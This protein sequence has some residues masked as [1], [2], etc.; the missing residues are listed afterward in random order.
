MNLFLINTFKM[1]EKFSFLKGN[2]NELLQDLASASIGLPCG[3][4]CAKGEMRL[5]PGMTMIA[6]NTGHGKTSALNFCTKAIVDNLTAD[7]KDGRVLYLT[8]EESQNDIAADFVTAGCEDL[9]D[10]IL[11]IQ[12]EGDDLGPQEALAIALRNSDNRAIAKNFLSKY[13]GENGRIDIC[14]TNAYAEDI[15][16][17]V[18]EKIGGGNVAAVVIDYFQQLTHSAGG[19]RVTQLKAITSQFR[20]LANT[21]KTPFL[22][23]VQFNRTVETP[24]EMKASAIGESGDIE[25]V[26]D[27]VVGLF[28]LAK[29][30]I[31]GLSSAKQKAFTA[32]L[33]TMPDFSAY[34]N[35]YGGGNIVLLRGLKGRN[36]ASD[37]TSYGVFYGS[38]KRLDFPSFEYG[39]TMNNSF[40]TYETILQSRTEHENCKRRAKARS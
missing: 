27:S 30:E 37:W 20:H 13:F 6:A 23:A 4:P 34:T 8:L 18:R 12:A 40:D 19:D 29:V 22:S 31:L 35:L 2:V 1:E 39:C 3:L 25:R 15:V 17:F 26:A 36:R 21:T 9:Y 24:C 38:L 11:K 16:D 14:Y 28:N 33:S 7:N 10:A 32:S 5:K